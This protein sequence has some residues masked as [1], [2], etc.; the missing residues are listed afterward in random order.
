MKPV[1]SVPTTT[2]DADIAKLEADG[3]LVIQHVD[4]YPSIVLLN[5]AQVVTGNQ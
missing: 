2:R 5:P 3:W 4:S 1:I